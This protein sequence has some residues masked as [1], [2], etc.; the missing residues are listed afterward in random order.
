MRIQRHF[1]FQPCWSC[2]LDYFCRARRNTHENLFG[3]VKGVAP[4]KSYPPPRA[5]NMIV[6]RKRRASRSNLTTGTRALNIL[7]NL[8]ASAITSDVGLRLLAPLRSRCL[9]VVFLHRFSVPDLGV[10][11]HDPRILGNHLE[12]LRRHRYRLLSVGDLLNQIDDAKPL[13]KNALVFT[14]DDGYA[15]FAQV[16]A[17]VFEAYDCPVTVFLITDFVS[18][19]I[20]NW[21]DQVEWA[22]LHTDRSSVGMEFGGESVRLAWPNRLDRF[23]A[24]DEF[25]ERLKRVRDGEKGALIRRLGEALEVDIPSATPQQYAGMNWDD[26]RRWALSGITYGPHTVTHPILTQVDDGRADTEIFESWRTLTAQTDAA[27]PVFCYPNGTALDFSS[28]EKSS[29]VRA[30]MRAALSTIEGSLES[31]SAGVSVPDRLAIPRFAYVE[32]K[33][34]FVQI[35]SGIEQKKMRLWRK[36]RPAGE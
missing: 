24:S 1:A 28:R 32:N 34:G 8:L 29:V 35:A 16:A 5:S 19:R 18:G 12:Y 2:F 31:S 20:W 9:T 26:V 36:S 30:G 4:G 17:P 14:V 21:F 11:G 23:G 3:K 27:V 15:D 22:F 25:V 10:P 6:P 33:A 7:K 13:S